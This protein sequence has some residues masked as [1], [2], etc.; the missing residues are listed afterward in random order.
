MGEVWHK[1]VVPPR[2]RPLPGQWVNRPACAMAGPPR[3][4]YQG[5]FTDRFP[6]ISA[7]GKLFPTGDTAARCL[8]EALPRPVTPAIVK[9]FRNTTNPAPGAKRIFYSRADDPDIAAHLTHGITSGSSVA[10][11]S[12]VNPLPK[13]D[14]QQKIQDRKEAIYFSNREAPLGRSHDQSAMLPQGLDITNT[15]FGTKIIQDK[16]AGELINPPKTFEEVDKEAREG[17]DLY[18]VSYNDYYSGEAI[19]RKYDSPNFNKS[20]VY[21]IETPHFEDGRNVSKSLNWLYDWQLKRAAKTV[22]KRMDDFKEKFQPQIGKVLDPIAET[23]NVPA[24]HTFGMLLRPDECGVGDLLHCR[25]PSEFLR[26]KDRERAVLAAVRQ[27]LKKVNY[28]NFDM[29]LEAFRHYDKNGDGM[30]DK[31]DLRK[32][33]FQLNLKL[34]SELLDTLFDYCDLDKDGLINYLEFVNFLNWKDKMA[35]EEFEEKVITKGNKLDVPP[36]SDTMTD[37][38]PLLKQEDLV[39]KEA[40][41]SGK[42]PKMLTRPTDS[43]FADYQTT[44]SQ[45]NAVVGGLPTDHYPVRGVPT[46]RSDIL[47]PRIRRI[48][49]RNNYGDEANAYALLFPSVFSQ[50]GVYEGDFFKL[51]PKAE[52]AQ[53]LRNIGVNISDER[54]ED[55][56]KQACM[57]KQKEEVCVESIRNILDEMHASHTKDCC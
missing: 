17:H 7:A 9:K 43:V 30:I 1:L 26:G 21:G 12:L 3:P 11:V 41:S 50:K 15:T 14:F 55:I 18:V 35:V 45:Y 27:S 24:D 49:D 38:E 40:G 10:V 37:D 47:A 6:H 57:K 51:R 34:D 13:T 32:S 20:N 22:S 44:S 23:M 52:V 36:Q 54:F 46:I 33:C 48:S 25:A 42:T 19:N 29:L 53:I 28:E 16:S 4:V 39:L 56:W 5:S 2:A 31:N 8:T